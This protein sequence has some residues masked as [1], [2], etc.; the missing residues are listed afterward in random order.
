MTETQR[1]ID[2]RVAEFLEG[3]HSLLHKL[4]SWSESP[5]SEVLLQ[6]KVELIHNE[7]QRYVEVL[8]PRPWLPYGKGRKV[9]ALVLLALGLVALVTPYNWLFLLFFIGLGLSPRV[10]A[11]LYKAVAIDAA[12][13]IPPDEHKPDELEVAAEQGDADAQY[14][15]GC[16]YASEAEQWK[17]LSRGYGDGAY[18]WYL[19]SAEQG[20]A[21]A[22]YR[23]GEL[24]ENDAIAIVLYRLAAEQDD[25]DAQHKLGRLYEHGRGVEQDVVEAVRWYRLAAEQEHAR[26]QFALHL[27]YFFGNG[28]ERDKT[29]SEQWERRAAENGYV[30]YV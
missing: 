10:V 25:A 16:I 21:R 6:K 8:A 19:L 1:W 20:H 4:K 14:R 9:V 2:S 11:R 29:K 30:G 15:L 5:S 22:Y 28:V 3:D 17:H 27:M 13:Y 24:Q 26:A 12:D 18:W 23:L 7:W